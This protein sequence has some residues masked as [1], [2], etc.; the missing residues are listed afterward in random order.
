MC[1]WWFWS[2]ICWICFNGKTLGGVSSYVPRTLSKSWEIPLGLGLKLNHNMGEHGGTW[3]RV[4]WVF[5]TNL[6]SFAQK[7]WTFRPSYFKRLRLRGVFLQPCISMISYEDFA[8]VRPEAEMYKRFCMVLS[9]ILQHHLKTSQEVALRAGD[10]RWTEASE[11]EDGQEMTRAVLVA[12]AGEAAVWSCRL[13]AS[14]MFSPFH[15]WSSMRCRGSS[16]CSGFT[17]Q[18]SVT[19]PWAASR[20][21]DSGKLNLTRS[22]GIPRMCRDLWGSLGA[23]EERV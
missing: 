19:N 15:L 11:P 10:Q 7:S 17:K 18:S 2:V 21:L 8:G 5:T 3:S 12:F 16:N 4:D 22:T 23:F 13:K 9:S 14:R 20:V 6:L 1:L